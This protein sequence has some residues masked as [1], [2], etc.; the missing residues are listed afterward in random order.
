MSQIGN[1]GIVPRL[2][3]LSGGKGSSYELYVNEDNV[4]GR[5]SECTVQLIFES[6]SSQHASIHIEG[7]ISTIEDLGS[8][9]GTLLGSLEEPLELEPGTTYTLNHGDSIVF[10]VRSCLCVNFLLSLSSDPVFSWFACFFACAI[11]CQNICLGI[12]RPFLCSTSPSTC[13]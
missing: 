3:V 7:G 9:N 13:H 5:G 6:L 12:P 8:T 2:R 1:K 4:I 11:L 10:G